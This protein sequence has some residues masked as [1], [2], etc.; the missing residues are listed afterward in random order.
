MFG[1][2]TS[3]DQLFKVAAKFQKKYGQ[4]QTLQQIIENA[5]SYGESSVN[6]IM[7]FPAQIKKD[8]ADLGINVTLSSGTF[9]GPS[10]DVSQPSVMPAEVA[11]NYA[12]LPD[13]IKEYLERNIKGFP[14]IPMGTTTLRYSGRAPGEGVAQR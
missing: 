14:Q 3:Q 8:Q 11:G 5:A 6:G 2:K 10:I 13:Q 4:T 12:K 9:G 1:M 7:N